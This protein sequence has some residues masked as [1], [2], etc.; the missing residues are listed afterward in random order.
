MYRVP[1]WQVSMLWSLIEP[2]ITITGWPGR[3]QFPVMALSY[4]HKASDFVGGFPYMVAWIA[5]VGICE[6]T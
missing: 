3:E 4:M 5:V 6:H 2:P 1:F